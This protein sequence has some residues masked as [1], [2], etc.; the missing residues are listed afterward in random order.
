LLPRILLGSA[1]ERSSC[2]AYWPICSLPLRQVHLASS[3]PRALFAQGPPRRVVP[4]LPPP[5]P[6]Q[7]YLF[8]GLCFLCIQKRFSKKKKKKKRKGNTSSAFFARARCLP[9][10]CPCLRLRSSQPP[11]SSSPIIL[12]CSAPRLSLVSSHPPAAP[13]M[14]KKQKT[15][16]K[17]K[18]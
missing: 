18:L 13:E 15:C 10:P 7:F 2:L 11:Q 6:V 9:L 1:P 12:R 14:Q 3:C 5:F 17:N 16:T 4:L 8:S